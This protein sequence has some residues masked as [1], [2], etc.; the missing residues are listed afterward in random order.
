MYKCK[1]KTLK[2]KHK[3]NSYFPI[4]FAIHCRNKI[5]F[6]NLLHILKLIG[7]KIFKKEKTDEFHTFLLPPSYFNINN[8]YLVLVKNKNSN[9]QTI[10]FKN[11][12]GP[13]LGFLIKSKKKLYELYYLLCNKTK[14]LIVDKPDEISLFIDLICGEIIEISVKK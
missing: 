9:K 12:Q 5:K 2:N 4:K 8:F 10:K 11:K 1:N 3:G 14:T 7:F 13:H 6:K